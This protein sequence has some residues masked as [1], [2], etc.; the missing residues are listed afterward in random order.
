[1]LKFQHGVNSTKIS[2]KDRE[3][4]LMGNFIGSVG[5]WSV[6]LISGLGFVRSTINI[7]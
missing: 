2:L 6:G 1:M 5:D 7:E 3:S 4:N